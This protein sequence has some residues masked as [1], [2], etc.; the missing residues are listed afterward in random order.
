MIVKN[1]RI[2]EFRGIKSCKRPI[3]LSNFTVLI[4][5]NN[6]GK[7]TILEA[8]SL[9]PSPQTSEYIT[10]RNKIDFIRDLHN[11]WKSP[12]DRPINYKSLIYQY[13]GTSTIE[14]NRIDNKVYNI[15]INERKIDY[16][17]RPND[18]MIKSEEKT[19]QYPNYLAKFLQVAMEQSSNSVLFVPFDTDYIKKIE[20]KID[21]IKDLIIKKGIHIKVAKSLNKCVDDEYS[22][23]LFGE[24]MR[25]RKILLDNFTYVRI[26][27]LGSGAE[28][29]V[30]IMALIEAIN[31]KLILIDDFEAGLHPTM[32]DI[33]LEWLIEI[34]SQ[35]VISTHSIDIL[36]KLT[37]I[38]A[39]D[40]DVLFLKKSNDDI[41]DYNI[42]KLDEI[43][44]LL[45]AN[46]DPRRFN[47]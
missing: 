13:A 2:K 22:E 32:I 21:T 24:P 35:V 27:D 36:Y 7:S 12:K 38:E 20:K 11:Q 30:K 17:F 31:P 3:E 26:N 9:L 1:L 15:L 25:I 40:S 5:R 34:D 39:K 42:L 8:L 28:K 45:N 33:F 16:N 6:S 43:E 14:Y 46:L 18:I 4:G 10:G 29:L 19:S 41:L 23:I 47:F 44:D 37:D